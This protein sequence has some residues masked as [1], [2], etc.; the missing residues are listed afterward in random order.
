MQNVGDSGCISKSM[1]HVFRG[2]LEFV[3]ECCDKS[4][5]EHTKNQLA[6]P[7]LVINFGKRS[8]NSP[9]SALVHVRLKL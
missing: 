1:V 4:R 7:N 6:W 8:T 9:V 3:G 2:A 5:C